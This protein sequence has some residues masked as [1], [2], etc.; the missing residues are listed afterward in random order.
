MMKSQHTR[1]QSMTRTGSRMVWFLVTVTAVVLA[2]CAGNQ[3]T[4]EDGGP[5]AIADL[6]GG[7]GPDATL[8]VDCLLPGKIKKLGTRVTFVTPR[9][10]IK[11]SSQECEIRGGE[12][13]AYD[14]AD[15]KTALRVWQPLA[16]QGDMAAQTYVGAIY[17]KGLGVL[18]NFEEAAK[19][20]RLAAEQDYSRAQHALGYLYELG[21]GVEKNPQEAF[22]WYRKAAGF[23]DETL[24]LTQVAMSSQDRQALEQARKAEEALLAK[25][26]QQIK[27]RRTELDVMAGKLDTLK[28]QL[29]VAAA[30]KAPEIAQISEREQTAAS[31]INA[32]IEQMRARSNQVE[33]ELA[34][35]EKRLALV[36]ATLDQKNQEQQA[37]AG[38]VTKLAKEVGQ[39]ARAVEEQRKALAVEVAQ[40]AK[41]KAQ[42]EQRKQLSLS[43]EERQDLN[44]NLEWV[45]Q[46]WEKGRRELAQ[47]DKAL[48]T[49][50]QV[51][52][53]K[54]KELN[55]L[56]KDVH[57]AK[58]GLQAELKKIEQGRQE[59]TA[60]QAKMD[61]ERL[62]LQLKFKKE[63]ESRIAELRQQQQ[64]IAQLENQK[65]TNQN[66]LADLQQAKDHTQV[67]MLAPRIELIDPTL[68]VT[69]GIKTGGAAAQRVAELPD[70]RPP[71]LYMAGNVVERDI[72]GKVISPKGLLLL[73]VN[74]RKVSVNK[75]GMFSTA[76]EVPANGAMIDV[77]AVDAVGNRTQKQFVLARQQQQMA[78]QAQNVTASRAATSARPN[79]NFGN[80]YALVIGNNDYAHL[81]KLRTPIND[82]TEIARVLKE[83]YAFKEVRTLLNAS[84]YQIITA[85]NQLR[86]DLT[87]NDNLL[88]YYAGHGELDRVNMK[89][90]WLPVDA[91]RE[92]TANWISNS[93]LTEL[94]N[95]IPAKH[96]L[97]VAD[98]CYSGIMTRSVMTNIEP[99]KSTN[100]KTNWIEKMV[101]KRSRTVLTSGGVAPVMDEGGGK[102]SVFALSLITALR[103]NTDVMDGQRLYREVSA[104]VALAA[105]RFNI[106]Q[107]PEYAPIKH[108][109]HESGDFFLVPAS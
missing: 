92:S 70:S 108:A 30:R 50:Q 61:Q 33:A 41:D 80:Y 83:K 28:Q 39:L 66:L 23:K 57:Q 102:H 58:A 48:N 76:M 44:D 1:M 49:Q 26:Q 18:P 2:G 12:Y 38:K 67:A 69:R 42:L 97:V 36:Q 16:E 85:M 40:L 82:T 103:N 63:R 27:S 24:S 68:P 4:G 81:P 73:T 5:V 7:Q 34:R 78:S 31:R 22:R 51:A 3:V 89:G 45:L 60:Q 106:E 47:I 101:A 100:A 10:P 11:A 14:R 96:V 13:A 8:I 90:Q 52:L 20:Y 55:K 105:D 94:I 65:K 37:K 91:E 9:R 75:N 86:K 109:G 79:V 46:Q 98:S 15:Y 72:V 64:V 53:S 59:L 25:I 43:A 19:W 29:E 6:P 107:I 77:V 99:G 54:G 35:K 87:E 21:L 104:S 93:S 84:R 17:E 88:I 95:A 56:L 71:V 74:D 32:R 62:A